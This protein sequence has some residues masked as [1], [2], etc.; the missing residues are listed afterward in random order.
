MKRCIAC[1]LCLL[2]CIAALPVTAAGA[3]APSAWAEAEVKEAISIGFVPEELQSNYQ[4]DITREEFA[5]LAVRLCMAQLRYVGSPE[6]F[7]EDYR[8]YYRDKEGNPAGA[9]PTEFSDAAPWG[10]VASAL[11][12]V[13]G[14]GDGTFDP[15][16]LI[17]RQEAAAMVA[18]TYLA[19]SGQTALTEPGSGPVYG[20]ADQFP[21]W[22]AEAIGWLRYQAVMEGDNYGNFLPQ[23]HLTREQAILIFLRLAR[24]VYTREIGLV[25]YEEELERILFP[26]EGDFSLTKMV[27][28]ESAAA[29]QGIEADGTAVLWVVYRTGG[30]TELYGRLEKEIL[31]ITAVDILSLD[32]Q[33]LALGAA[34]ELGMYVRWF[35][36][37]G[38]IYTSMTQVLNPQPALD[39]MDVTGFDGTYV[40]ASEADGMA[41]YDLTGRRIFSAPPGTV[42]WQ[43]EGGVFRH[44]GAG[45]V[46][47]YT[48]EGQ[49]FR[50]TPWAAGTDF[51]IGQA[52]VQEEAGGPITVLNT[53]GETLNTLDSFGGTIADCSMGCG[54]LLLAKDG[55]HYLLS[56]GDGSLFGG[57]YLDVGPFVG[58]HA[59]V[60]TKDGWGFI[61]QF[62]QNTISCQYQA[63]YPFNHIQAVVQQ[64]DGTFTTVDAHGKGGTIG[65]G[66][67]ALT[68]LTIQ[69]YALGVRTGEDG[70]A[71]TM[72]ISLVA[73]P[74]PLPGERSEYALYGATAV[75][76]AGG[77][78][79]LFGKGGAQVFPELDLEGAWGTADSAAVL[80][81][82]DGRYY[83]Y[84]PPR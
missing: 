22:A 39:G 84:N 56:I 32:D 76:T 52:A 36:L 82:T 83:L 10:T 65:S 35:S 30:R 58:T 78:V 44:E 50:Q 29:I 72:L 11:G 54:W 26:A 42:T 19:Y 18:R 81:K 13:Q 7:L 77:E 63:V 49:P 69:G 45:G 48:A 20:D 16:G 43:K 64:S 47:Y 38:S 23:S 31:G 68:P 71:Q 51:C 80:L 28:S 67:T 8:R 40:F 57:E 15:D 25:P 66:W 73:P 12:I 74:A 79:S 70:T 24:E 46:M 6:Q 17:T 55:R 2:L 3:S 4:Q 9:V 5:Q 75:R 27:E 60:R 34:G 62:F 53:L 33:G 1:F 21:D 61:D 37:W 14:R 41:V 59:A